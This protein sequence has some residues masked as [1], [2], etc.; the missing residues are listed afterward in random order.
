MNKKITLSLV[1]QVVR[2]AIT[3]KYRL[4]IYNSSGG[5]KSKVKMSTGLVSS[6]GCEGQSVTWP[7]SQLLLALE[8]RGL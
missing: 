2:A 7:L 3:K 8:V 1:Y 4:A 5:P 6:E